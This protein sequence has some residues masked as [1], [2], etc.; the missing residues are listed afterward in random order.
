MSA[1][2]GTGCLYLVFLVNTGS[3]LSDMLFTSLRSISIHFRSF[4]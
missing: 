2:N 4:L 3:V 1:S